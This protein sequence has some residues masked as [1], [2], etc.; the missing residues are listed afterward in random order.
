[1]GG[2]QQLNADALHVSALFRL[3][4]LQF[5][6]SAIHS[7]AETMAMMLTKGMRHP[8]IALLSPH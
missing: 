8:G 4:S 3:P 2:H 6:H 7:S 5:T 1:M